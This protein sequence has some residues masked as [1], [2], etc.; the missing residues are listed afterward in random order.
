MAAYRIMTF[1]MPALL[2][3]YIARFCMSRGTL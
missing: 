2:G 1:A 3:G